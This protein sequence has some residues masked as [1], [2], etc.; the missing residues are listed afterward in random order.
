[1]NKEQRA[2]LAI[3]DL[4][5]EYAHYDAIEKLDEYLEKAKNVPTHGI[6]DWKRWKKNMEQ[7]IETLRKQQHERM[8]FQEEFARELIEV[9]KIR[10]INMGD[11]N[12]RLQS[13]S[14]TTGQK[15]EKEIIIAQET[16]KKRKKAKSTK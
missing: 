15:R 16:K 6:R 9:N 5:F 10:T 13:V 12:H 2:L 3:P 1:M 14:F 4:A 8:N 7:A 11:P